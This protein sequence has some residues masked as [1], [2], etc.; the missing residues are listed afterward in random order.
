M[1]SK[2]ET[3]KQRERRRTLNVL[4]GA[5]AALL[6]VD[7]FSADL[8]KRHKGESRKKWHARRRRLRRLGLGFFK[9]RLQQRQER[10]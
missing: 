3:R 4:I 5:S 6:I 10:L 1:K 2:R 9:P 8:M 7:L